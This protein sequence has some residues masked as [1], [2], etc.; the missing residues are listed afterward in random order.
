[1]QPRLPSWR[2]GVHYLPVSEVADELRSGQLSEVLPDWALP[3]LGVYAVWPD[4][5]PQKKLACR[6]IDH[7]R[8]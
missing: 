5:V 1:M 2:V 7:L 4:L 8:E 6:L 3:D